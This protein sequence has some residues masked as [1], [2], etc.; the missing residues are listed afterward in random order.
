MTHPG[1]GPC[2]Q[3]CRGNTSP[4]CRAKAAVAPVAPN[5]SCR[6]RHRRDDRGTLGVLLSAQERAPQYR[7]AARKIPSTKLR[8]I[9]GDDAQGAIASTLE[10]ARGW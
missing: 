5:A 10:Q 3:A 4:P 7:A 2:S 8:G 9:I 6:E 1:S